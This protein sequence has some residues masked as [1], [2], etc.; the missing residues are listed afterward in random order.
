MSKETQAIRNGDQLVLAE[1]PYGNGWVHHAPF[2]RGSKKGALDRPDNVIPNFSSNDEAIIWVE[3]QKYD[4]WEK[5]NDL[6]A[7]I[8]KP[9]KPSSPSGT[10][11]NVQKNALFVFGVCTDFHDFE[12]RLWN[13]QTVSQLLHETKI[14]TIRFWPP[15][16][17][18]KNGEVPRL[19]DEVRDDANVFMSLAIRQAL[20]GPHKDSEKWY[21]QPVAKR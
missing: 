2:K 12:K 21:G 15:K 7:G 11:R 13:C 18:F 14:G 3:Q 1:H 10:Y 20:A 6:I 19:T 4:L 9:E 5:G 17:R 16:A 8:S